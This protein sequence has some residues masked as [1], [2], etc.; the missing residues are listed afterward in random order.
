MLSSYLSGLFLVM[1]V[2]AQTAPEGSELALATTTKTTLIRVTVPPSFIETTT[3]AAEPATTAVEIVTTHITAFVTVAPTA[4][5]MPLST[6]MAMTLVN[7]LDEDLVLSFK[8]GRDT[9]QHDFESAFGH[10]GVVALPTGQH[11]VYSFPAKWDGIIEVG[12]EENVDNSLIE[13]NTF[14]ERIDVDVSFVQGFSVPIVC[15][16]DGV[17]VTGCNKQ[18]FAYGTCPPA[19]M[20]GTRVCHNSAR[21]PDAARAGPFFTP[22]QSAAITFPTDGGNFNGVPSAPRDIVCCI[23]NETVCPANPHQRQL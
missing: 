1:G 5:T 23:G 15:S 3:L 22:C 11:A 6:A 14:N 13:G 18:L 4:G 7:H 12:Y 17:V 20:R 10:P 16:N 21:E 2:I 19:D 9:N 8:V